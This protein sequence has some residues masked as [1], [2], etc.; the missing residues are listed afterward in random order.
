MTRW[1]HFFRTETSVSTRNF[2]IQIVVSTFRAIP[3]QHFLLFGNVFALIGVVAHFG[4]L[5]LTLLRCAIVGPS[6]NAGQMKEAVT[7]LTRPYLEGNCIS[8]NQ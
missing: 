4:S 7:M 2:T 1:I 8:L 3:L 5:L 6:L